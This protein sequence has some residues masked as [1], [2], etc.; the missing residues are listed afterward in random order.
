MLFLE[1][2]QDMRLWTGLKWFR[3]CL[4][5]HLCECGSRLVGKMKEWNLWGAGDTLWSG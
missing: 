4:F 3:S 1:V 5:K 2:L